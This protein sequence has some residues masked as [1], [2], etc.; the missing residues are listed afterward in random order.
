MNNEN[1][2]ENTDITSAGVSA[3]QKTAITV[4]RTTMFAVVAPVKRII[5]VVDVLPR[6]SLFAE[7]RYRLIEADGYYIVIIDRTT[8]ESAR[9][10]IFKCFIYE[11]D[12]W[13]YLDLYGIEKKEPR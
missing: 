12:A 13:S 3:M 8:K 4:N 9:D 10:D 2:G 7:Q 11:D 6:T 5:D 1:S